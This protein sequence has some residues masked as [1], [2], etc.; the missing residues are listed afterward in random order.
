MKSRPPIEGLSVLDLLRPTLWMAAAA[1]A[2]GFGGYL[3]IGLKALQAA[4][5]L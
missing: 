2:A 4:A 5:P 1:F 3:V